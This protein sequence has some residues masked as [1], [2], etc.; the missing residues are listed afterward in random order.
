MRRLALCVLLLGSILGTLPVLAHAAPPRA[1]QILRAARAAIVLPVEWDGV[2][3]TADSVY[4]CS[5]AFQN[6]DAGA[7]T[8]CGGKDYL[9]G[10]PDPGL[11]FDC[12]GTATSTTIDVTCTGSQEVFPNCMANYTITTHGTRSGDTF[13]IV[14][15][16]ALDYTGTGEG[17]E[18]IQPYCEQTNSHGTRTGP[19]PTLYCSVP[20]RTQSWG[21]LKIR[22]R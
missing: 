18:L 10:G 19:A 8:L 4:D 14:S 16:F 2:W 7:D 12:T 6:T 1:E 3:T 22:Y 13:Y 5:G 9:T 11:W 17:C 21:E 20:T 15:T